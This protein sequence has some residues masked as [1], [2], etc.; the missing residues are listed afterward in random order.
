MFF[1]G[2]FNATMDKNPTEQVHPM[3]QNPCHSLGLS[4]VTTYKVWVNA[5]DPG[6]SGV[7][8]RRWYRFT[9]KSNLGNTPPVLGTPS[10]TNGSTGNL[11]SL[12]WS[13]PIT[14]PQGD[15]FSWTIQCNNKQ[16]NSGTD[17]SNGTKSLSLSGLTYATTYKVW[18]NVTDPGGSGQYTR[19]WYTF[20]TKA[21]TPPTFGV[22]VPANAS[23]GNLLN[24]TWSIP[25]YDL[26]GNAFSWTI[27]CS[28]GQKSNGTGASNGT[29]SLPLSGLTNIT[30]YKVWVN[31]TD[32][33]GSGLY[34]RRWYSFTTKQPDLP[35]TKPGTPTGQTQGRFEQDYTYTTSSTDPNG[36]RLY[37]MWDWGDGTTSGWLGPFNSG[38]LCLATHSWNTTNI[39]TV[40]VKAKDTTGLESP[41][42]NLLLVT[43][44]PVFIVS[45]GMI[46]VDAKITSVE[47]IDA[48]QYSFVGTPVEKV[49]VIG[50]GAYSTGNDTDMVPR[51]SMKTF[52][53]VSEIQGIAYK[54]LQVSDAYQQFSFIVT[55]RN[56]AFLT[57]I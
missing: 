5:T 45:S 11:L 29:K 13:I 34:T 23:T 27:Q 14:D 25:I 46:I 54:T 19:R 44:H 47:Q 21:N 50:Y 52:T 16:V 9:T 39:Y 36:D 53:N 17:A 20:T 30:T 37:Y 7:Y 4:N 22:P 48:F 49:T 38:V 42:S 26:E 24:V 31:A 6:G 18:V 43:I 41:W 28:N 40:I 51:F 3:E 33:L 8:T 55:P 12:S 15:V 32:V 2:R 57:V 10:P 1:P 35:P 56:K